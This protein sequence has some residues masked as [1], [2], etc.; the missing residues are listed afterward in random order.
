MK[1]LPETLD[2]PF[3]I[4]A[5]RKNGKASKSSPLFRMLLRFYVLYFFSL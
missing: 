1:T 4:I 2:S 3:T 5:L